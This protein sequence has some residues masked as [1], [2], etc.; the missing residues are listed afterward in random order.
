[1][2]RFISIG[3]LAKKAGI[4]ITKIRYYERRGLLDANGRSEAGYRRYLDSALKRI[5]FI[6]KAQSLGFTLEEIRYLIKVKNH[7]E[8]YGCVHLKAQIEKKIQQIEAQISSLQ[9]INTELKSL[10][11]QCTHNHF[12]DE[13]PLLNCC[14][15]ST[16]IEDI[17]ESGTAQSICCL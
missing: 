8:T 1:M 3:Q 10:Y 6:E 17:E 9:Q 7:L 12:S 14:E 2:K 15:E 5:K 16:S 4:N 13:C 11:A